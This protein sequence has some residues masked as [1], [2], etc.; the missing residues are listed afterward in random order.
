MNSSVMKWLDHA[1]KDLDTA[2]Y[3]F[4][5]AKYEGSALFSQQCVEK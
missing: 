4:E 1:I 2:R 5:G 3:L